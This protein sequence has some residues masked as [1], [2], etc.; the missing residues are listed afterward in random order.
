MTSKEYETHKPD[1][2][3]RL[4]VGREYLVEYLVPNFR[5]EIWNGK[6]FNYLGES[7]VPW[8]RAVEVQALKD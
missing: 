6:H 2:L 3:S 4:V 1:D 7:N 5:N 8:S